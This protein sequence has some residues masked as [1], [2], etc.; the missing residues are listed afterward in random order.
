MHSSNLLKLLL[1]FNCSLFGIFNQGY[2]NNKVS[3][4]ENYL[5]SSASTVIV[6]LPFVLHCQRLV[7]SVSKLL[8]IANVHQDPLLQYAL[9]LKV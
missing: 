6:R 9:K 5:V 3:I 8:I 2:T 7:P 4:P 1:R